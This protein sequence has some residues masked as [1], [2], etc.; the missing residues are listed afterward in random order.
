MLIDDELTFK[1]TLS[2]K[3]MLALQFISDNPILPM[4]AADILIILVSVHCSKYIPLY[5]T[6]TSF[7]LILQ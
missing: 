6:D 5:V 4:Y 7:I 3:I 2:S 1:K